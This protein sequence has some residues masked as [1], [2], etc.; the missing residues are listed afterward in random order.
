MNKEDIIQ[1]CFE[2][3]KEEILK[4]NNLRDGS[5]CEYCGGHTRPIR[6]NI[7]IDLAQGKDRTSTMD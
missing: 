1:K 3:K 6:Y 2:C 4:W 7:G 5:F